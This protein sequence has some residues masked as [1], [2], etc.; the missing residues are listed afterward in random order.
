M[1]VVPITHQVFNQHA[2]LHQP[3][4]WGLKWCRELLG[5]GRRPGLLAEDID[6]WED[7]A[8]APVPPQ[9][10]CSF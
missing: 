5:D 1:C 7:A 6:K 10:V 9:M 2:G 3:L 4:W 8:P